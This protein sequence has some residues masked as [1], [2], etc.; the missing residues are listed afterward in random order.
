MVTSVGLELIILDKELQESGETDTDED[1][2][3]DWQEIDQEKVAIN[4][5][6]TIQLKNYYDYLSKYY[7][8]FNTSLL[9]KFTNISDTK[10]KSLKSILSEIYVLPILSNPT[11]KDSDGDELLD[12]IDNNPLTYDELMNYF[13]VYKNEDNNFIKQADW[14]SDYAYDDENVE[15]FEVTQYADMVDVWNNEFG[16]KIGNIHLYLHGGEG[17]LFFKKETTSYSGIT[18]LDELEI[19]NKLYLYS[20]HGGSKYNESTVASELAKKVSEKSV[21]AL[22]NDSVD[23][24]NTFNPF[25]WHEKLPL[26]HDGVGYWANFTSMKNPT[27][28]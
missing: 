11:K 2:L 14:M 12:N 22:V 21:Y 5:D 25:L 24:F 4:D 23:Y 28:H 9:K 10:G 17:K 3:T 19:K 18:L 27:E 16:Q 26:M 7:P 6:G 15:H 8:S 13:I 1:T 20:C